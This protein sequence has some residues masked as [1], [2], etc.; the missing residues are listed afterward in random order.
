MIQISKTK[1]TNL[2]LV[3]DGQT[4]VVSFRP[5]S[6]EGYRLAMS[7]IKKYQ[8]LS[9]TRQ[10][11]GDDMTQEQAMQVMDASL[12]LI[13]SF[14]SAVAEIVGKDQYD[15]SLK[16]VE[17]D[18]PFTAWIEIMSEIIRGYSAFF[19]SAVSTEGE[20]S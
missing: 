10:D 5:S 11:F 2:T 4:V 16:P 19:E 8:D 17:E 6:M 18:I 7:V 9:K 15:A 3:I 13:E 20:R 14:R 12:S 1:H